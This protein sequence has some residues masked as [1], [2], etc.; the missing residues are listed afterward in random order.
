[1]LFVRCCCGIVSS[2][3][4]SC[5]VWPPFLL[6]TSGVPRSMRP[7]PRL[8][9]TELTSESLTTE[10]GAVWVQ[11]KCLVHAASAAQVPNMAQRLSGQRFQNPLK[12]KPCVGLAVARCLGLLEGPLV[13]TCPCAT[14]RLCGQVNE[15]VKKRGVWMALLW[16]T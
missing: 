14:I 10:L 1:M 8:S 16:F 9:A 3:P 15:T 13:W 6:R 5:W 7:C 12:T 11:S 2:L 4:T